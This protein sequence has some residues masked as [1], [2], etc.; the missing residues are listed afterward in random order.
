MSTTYQR[1]SPRSGFTDSDII[2]MR[3]AAEREQL[4]SRQLAARYGINQTTAA[5]IVSGRTWSHIPSPKEMGNYVVY[6]DG[7]VFS[8]AAGRFMQVSTGRDGNIYIEMR[9]NG[10]R[11]KVAV[12]SLVAYAFLGARKSSK[13]SFRNGDSTDTHF[14]NLVVKR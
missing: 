14:T 6:P 1:Y 10:S 4:S 7:R 13:I 5:R 12:A 9:A 3:I 11:K 8:K 2:D